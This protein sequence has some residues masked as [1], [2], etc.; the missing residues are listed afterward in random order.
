M[1]TTVLP[2]DHRVVSYEAAGGPLLDVGAYCMIP[3]RVALQDNPLNRDAKPVVTTA[4]SKTR[5]GSD[6]ATTLVLDYPSLDAR[7]TCSMNWNA[8]APRD[9]WATIVGTKGEIV[10]HDGLYRIA[11]FTVHRLVEE[12]ADRKKAVWEEDRVELDFAGTGLHL[13]ADAVARDVRD[14]KIENDRVPHS[15]TL[16]TMEIFDQARREGGYVLPEGMEKI[17]RVGA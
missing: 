2:D 12:N 1:L 10:I 16:L 7:A 8:R 9:A 17:G 6:L 11:R 3:A 5:M 13:E 4:M 15:E 14:G